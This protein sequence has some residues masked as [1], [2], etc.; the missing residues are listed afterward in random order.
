MDVSH[1]E[2]LLNTFRR[3]HPLKLNPPFVEE[4]TSLELV[5][6]E[7]G[8]FV[9]FYKQR[10]TDFIFDSKS[11]VYLVGIAGAHV[12]LMAKLF[13]YHGGNPSLNVYAAADRYIVDG[14]NIF[15]SRAGSRIQCGPAFVAP[16]EFKPILRDIEVIL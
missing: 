9:N 10:D 5:F 2:Q 4:L 8:E 12:P 1:I 13:V 7:H 15:K 3:S 14:C 6:Y 11:G 16:S